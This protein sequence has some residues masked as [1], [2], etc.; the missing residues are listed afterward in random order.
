MRVLIADDDCVY[1]TLLTDLLGRWHFEVV[2]ASNGREAMDVMESEEPPR[3]V[4][5]DWEMPE[6]DGFEVARATRGGVVG[7][8]AYIL[9]ITGSRKKEDIMRVLVCGADD[10]LIKPFDPTDLKIRLRSA[11]RIMGLQDELDEL[12]RSASGAAPTAA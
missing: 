7:S 12:K 1:R 11:M 4:I 5:L 10:Y 2:A 6:I 9:M 8:G 3:L